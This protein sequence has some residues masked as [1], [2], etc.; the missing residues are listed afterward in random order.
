[1]ADLSTYARPYAKAVFEL[2]REGNSFK[3]WS[4]ALAALAKLLSDAK[5]AALLRNPAL[6]RS[7]LAALMAQALKGKVA[8]EALS[9]VRLLVENG[10]L[11]ATPAIAEQF[12]QL[13]AEAEARVDVEITSAAAVD[14]A[15]QDQLAAAVRKR[16]ARDVAITWNT[17]PALIAGA[18]IRAGDL[19][20]DGSV[21]GE[22]ERLQTAL[23]R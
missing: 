21:R 1:M 4:E 13:R 5:L 14:K 20:I 16:L 8:D 6:T 19:V 9:L 10:R 18:L 23:A 17:D 12:E 15:Q 11:A 2:A 7:E 3:V 22:L